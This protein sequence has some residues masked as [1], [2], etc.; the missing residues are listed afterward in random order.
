MFTMTRFAKGI[1]WLEKVSKASKA[2]KREFLKHSKYHQ[3]LEFKHGYYPLDSYAIE[4]VFPIYIFFRQG[5][6]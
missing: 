1:A 5:H 6:D 2:N 3:H 4:L